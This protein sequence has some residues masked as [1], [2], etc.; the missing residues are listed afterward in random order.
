MSV[1]EA[2]KLDSRSIMSVEG[3]KYTTL[4]SIHKSLPLS[5]VFGEVR[6][7]CMD[8][9]NATEVLEA[10][11]HLLGAAVEAPL[12]ELTAD[13]IDTSTGSIQTNS[14][15]SSGTN[16]GQHSLSDEI[17]MFLRHCGA[18]HLNV[19]HALLLHL[20]QL[21][22][23]L[24][25]LNV[26]PAM[27]SVAASP[28]VID[29]LVD[30]L[31]TLLD[32]DIATSVAAVGHVDSNKLLLA[33]ITCMT[34]L[35]LSSQNYDRLTVLLTSAMQVTG[36][37][38][39]PH[40]YRLVLRALNQY[41][42]ATSS[43]GKNK[44]LANT[45]ANSGASADLH[46]KPKRG[47]PRT[48]PLPA[49][50]GATHSSTSA[51]HSSSKQVVLTYVLTE[52]RN[53][54]LS[55]CGHLLEVLWEELPANREAATLLLRYLTDSCCA[56]T[57]T[58]SKSALT[59]SYIEPQLSDIC[60]SII[61][62]TQAGGD[63]F[64]GAAASTSSRGLYSKW[65]HHRCF[66]FHVLETMVSL[67]DQ[68]GGVW[69][70]IVRSM[71]QVCTWLIRT[72]GRNQY[73]LQSRLHLLIRTLYVHQP[74]LREN[75]LMALLRD[76]MMISKKTNISL[77]S[78]ADSNGNKG[79]LMNLGHAAAAAGMVHKGNP[80]PRMDTNATRQGYNDLAIDLV[81]ASSSS[82]LPRK[83]G[84]GRPPS[85]NRT[86][87]QQTGSRTSGTSLDSGS[88]LE[89]SSM[90]LLSAQML[91][92]LAEA[93]AEVGQCVLSSL[94]AHLHA[95]PMIVIGGSCSTYPLQLPVP[96]VLH[97]LCAC[98]AK[99]TML[100]QQ[101]ESS[102]L[103]LI[104]KLLAQPSSD[105][106]ML[107]MALG[108]YTTRQH[109]SQISAATSASQHRHNANMHVSP[110]YYCSTSL[111]ILLAA[112]YL[113][114]N[115]VLNTSFCNES[116]SSSHSS[117][118]STHTTAPTCHTYSA[119][120]R[121][122]ATWVMRALPHLTHDS[123]VTAVDIL[124]LIVAEA[125]DTNGM[126]KNSQLAAQCRNAL[127][128]VFK[129][130]PHLSPKT[131]T[132]TS[133]TKDIVL[134]LWKV[135]S[136]AKSLQSSLWDTVTTCASPST[137][138]FDMGSGAISS[139]AACRVGTAISCLLHTYSVISTDNEEQLIGLRKD[140][141]S[142]TVRGFELSALDQKEV[143]VPSQSQDK[144][145][146]HT[147]SQW[148]CIP[149]D[150]FLLDTGVSIAYATLTPIQAISLSWEKLFIVSALC[151]QVRSSYSER[152]CVGEHGKKHVSTFTLDILNKILCQ[153]AVCRAYLRVSGSFNHITGSN[154]STNTMM[155]SKSDVALQSCMVQ[156]SCVQRVLGRILASL[157]HNVVTAALLHVLD[158]SPMSTME[159]NGDLS[160]KVIDTL[161]T[162]MLTHGGSATVLHAVLCYLEKLER[163]SSSSEQYLEHHLLLT[164]VLR[165]DH[166]LDAI[167]KDKQILHTDEVSALTR[168]LSF[169]PI[170]GAY[171]EKQRQQR[172]ES[173]QEI[174]TT[175]TND[176]QL[177]SERRD[178]VL[179]LLALMCLL[180][181][182]LQSSNEKH[183]VEVAQE[184]AVLIAPDNTSATND[185]REVIH[186]EDESA[187]I[188]GLGFGA[189]SHNTTPHNEKKYHQCLCTLYSVIETS[190]F[191]L[192]DGTVAIA[193][194]KI[195][196]ALA[197]KCSL[198]RR[199]VS[200]T[201]WQLLVSLYTLHT[202]LSHTVKNGSDTGSTVAF[203]S[204]TPA[205]I[206]EL[207]PILSSFVATSEHVSSI[208]TEVSQYYDL[209]SSSNGGAGS[210]SR[211]T[212]LKNACHSI[213]KSVLHGSSSSACGTDG[214]APHDP[215]LL[216]P[217]LLFASW[218]VH[219][220]SH[221]QRQAGLS[222]I[223]IHSLPYALGAV[224]MDSSH[225]HIDRSERDMDI[226]ISA[227]SSSM[228]QQ[229]AAL[230]LAFLPLSLLHATPSMTT[231]ARSTSE[232]SS[233]NKSTI[234]VV[235]A[236]YLQHITAVK[237]FVWCVREIGTL[238]PDADVRECG[239]LVLYA[240]RV[241]R[242][243][244]LV[245]EEIAES[246]T[247]WRTSAAPKQS[248]NQFTNG[249]GS[250]AGHVS[251]LHNV[252]CWFLAVPH[253]CQRLAQA[254][255]ARFLVT[256][257]A[258]G[259]AK[260]T[261]V[262]SASRS[263]SH[264]SNNVLK[265]LT[266]SLPL[267]TLH[268]ERTATR[269]H[270]LGRSIGVSLEEP[271]VLRDPYSQWEG[272]LHKSQ[273]N[274]RRDQKAC[275][276]TTVKDCYDKEV[277]AVALDNVDVNSTDQL[278]SYHNDEQK[279]K[280]SQ[281]A[282]VDSGGFAFFATGFG[283]SGQDQGTTDTATITANTTS[284]YGSSGKGW[285]VYEPVSSLSSSTIGQHS[286]SS[287]AADEINQ[288]YV[289]DEEGSVELD[290]YDSE[291]YD[292]QSNDEGDSISEED[293]T[294]KRTKHTW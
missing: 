29:E 59:G 250:D 266:R 42:C 140:S 171:S 63:L 47:R 275:M 43:S 127:C 85:K 158:S 36:E 82:T 190:V 286:K 106:T 68:Y 229:F 69:T 157:P 281:L 110:G 282:P 187:D 216:P 223:A 269:L 270:R 49:A 182:N 280:E 289:D 114:R 237:Q 138:S 178:T 131:T 100:S 45:S 89:G 203:E 88:D 198:L 62:Y 77:L 103:I 61:A 118:P 211:C 141:N 50:A 251:H 155:A 152:I 221:T 172:N 32:S 228:P 54:S 101:V 153:A 161:P 52:L 192:Q 252:L 10:I 160:E 232:S 12:T 121:A 214:L 142:P 102:V 113:S 238:M 254:L 217:R 271:D 139:V 183:V 3:Q 208:L 201:S 120:E 79:V 235:A 128:I 167:E 170:L 90:A 147:W 288:V 285:G 174:D 186:D 78:R 204:G 261:T 34:E 6:L 219:T 222:T 46:V 146:L 31:H 115:S 136:L 258:S 207:W 199:R 109:Q 149:S 259:R 22:D 87:T 210:T 292:S 202:D 233:N 92:S 126:S 234:S 154:T 125:T 230:A 225:E 83:R 224:L 195:L 67:S 163:H 249:S 162:A 96:A 242:A 39:L 25:F 179:L 107:M 75:I 95:Q 5:V 205:G 150:S 240:L 218:W 74:S 236:P 248:G 94:T 196:S 117:Q 262:D 105:D 200:H 80:A 226:P 76:A 273:L 64:N 73:S 130:H 60:V 16:R 176:K 86:S 265:G 33:V 278:T 294:T 55:V 145:I 193:G 173:I 132:V 272:S 293:I 99:A 11:E 2:Q 257:S 169:I 184:L 156:A 159:E 72:L 70:R 65:L 283:A 189:D 18:L 1:F 53:V 241:C 165:K 151:G 220:Q 246:C 108:S 40:L 267:L 133:T 41:Y 37:E 124:A 38:E 58:M 290:D 287:H 35:T 255:Q 243:Q 13:T 277:I 263:N 21:M 213:L 185:L 30:V 181:A 8:N 244:L 51:Q 112:H 206:D 4:H 180:E 215:G 56:T 57:K 166:H 81:N 239:K 20:T 104:Q 134:S 279:V 23:P 48:V 123:I 209:G 98:V 212:A 26:I 84:R 71:W 129:K 27:Y 44:A 122:V 197:E 191:H 7:R 24:P 135:S 175:T 14:S 245:C 19:R 268:S 164:E 148:S 137:A 276:A 91:L 66:P 177:S 9:D 247:Q 256:T 143:S 227:V 291:D 97:C 231:T 116:G 274:F 194:M 93:H 111:G 253:W 260:R 28:S 168:L 144:E 284:S 17:A 119:D 188:L 264:S 15:S